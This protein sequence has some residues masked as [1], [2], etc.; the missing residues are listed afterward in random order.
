MQNYATPAVRRFLFLDM[1]DFLSAQQYIVSDGY[2]NFTYID[3]TSDFN[4][5]KWLGQE[6]GD[7]L[8][9][10]DDNTSINALLAVFGCIKAPHAL[11]LS[12]NVSKIHSYF[13]RCLLIPKFNYI[14]NSVLPAGQLF[15]SMQQ[16]QLEM[17]HA[18]KKLHS[19]KN[20]THLIGERGSGK[21]TLL[22][23]WIAELINAG[24]QSIILCSPSASA[25]KNT[26]DTMWRNLSN[27]LDV[28]RETFFFCSPENL[29]SK[30]NNG[31]VVIIDEAATLPKALLQSAV[32]YAQFHD[33]RLVLSTTLE[34]Y[35][36]TGQSYRLN[37][38]QYYDK[39]STIIKLKYPK[40]FAINDGLYQLC[41]Q[42]YRPQV[43]LPANTTSDGIHLL[44]TKAL[45]ERGWTMACFALLQEAHYKTT[46]NDLAR[47]YEKPALFVVMIDKGK[48]IAAAYAL[49]EALP[50]DLC[51]DDII[52]GTRRVKDAFT[53]QALIHAYG[54]IGLQTRREK[55]A[56]FYM[57][58]F[59]NSTI[60]RISRIAT[61]KNYRRQG[62]ATQL[63]TTLK[64]R[65]NSYG[66]DYLSTSF[67]GSAVNIAFWLQQG[68][69][70]A[71]VGLYPNKSNN[72][73]A[74]LMLYSLTD[75]KI[76]QQ[77]F[78]ALCGRHLRYFYRTYTDEHWQK[79][80]Q[81]TES[82]VLHAEDLSPMQM[83]SNVV[84]YYLD[85][86]WVLP[87]LWECF[88]KHLFDVDILISDE[89]FSHYIKLRSTHQKDK[90]LLIKLLC[91]YQ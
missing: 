73:Y 67:S 48:L 15:E 36:G 19:Q 3:T 11:V 59:T 87:I 54:K 9:Y 20:I 39:G 4:Q 61:D 1:P 79:L 24:Q 75:N 23:E 25:S 10:F 37:Y 83:L 18:K 30:L 90:K 63:L 71:R 50:D 65:M 53:Q 76:D 64:N 17:Y 52:R 69:T 49:I 31:V 58:P 89:L 16:Q 14:A 12:C 77:H 74:V 26:V 85:I 21:S 51:L 45:R 35:E 46:P 66:F 81:Y 91:L 34:G 80:L 5:N 88:N 33:F 22:G 44:N 56:S 62:I 43:S 82:T 78:A 28:S 13:K 42:I 47:F 40:R 7:T 2:V 6:L 41:R 8:I 55:N 27:G 70:P 68:F 32:K 57:K 38:L 86:N 29:K 72:E 60:L 84:D